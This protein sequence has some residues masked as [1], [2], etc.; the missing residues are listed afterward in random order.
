MGKEEL[1][2]GLV[3]SINTFPF[4]FQCVR[5]RTLQYPKRWWRQVLIHLAFTE[6]NGHIFYLTIDTQFSWQNP[7]AQSHNNLTSQKQGLLVPA[8]LSSSDASIAEDST[9]I[10]K[11]TPTQENKQ[12]LFLDFLGLGVWEHGDGIWW[13]P[14]DSG[15]PKEKEHHGRQSSNVDIQKI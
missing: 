5:C 7:K 9:P 1:F 6:V 15:L 14:L 11:P 2:H 10:C 13:L 12:S 4:L 8:P 3:M